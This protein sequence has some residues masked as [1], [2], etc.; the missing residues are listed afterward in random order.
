MWKKR[1]NVNWGADAIRDYSMCKKNVNQKVYTFNTVAE[2]D[3]FLLGVEEGHDW[4]DYA[5]LDELQY[6]YSLWLMGKDVEKVAQ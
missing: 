6:E 3:A 5:T 4:D 1:A 2:R